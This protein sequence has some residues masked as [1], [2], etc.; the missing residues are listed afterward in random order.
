MEKTFLRGCRAEIWTR[1]CHTTGQR[2]IKRALLQHNWA[3]LHPSELRWPA[4]VLMRIH[5]LSGKR[6]SRHRDHVKRVRSKSDIL[7]LL[8]FRGR[9]CL[10][11][12]IEWVLL[13]RIPS[14]WS[15]WGCGRSH[16]GIGHLGCNGFHNFMIQ[17]S[18]IAKVR[19]FSV[20]FSA[21][22]FTLIKN[23]LKKF[24]LKQILTE[25][26]RKYIVSQHLVNFWPVSLQLSQ[27]IWNEQKCFA[28]FE[29]YTKK[30][31]RRI[32]NPTDKLHVKDHM[33]IKLASSKP[34]SKS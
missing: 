11:Y 12:S 20:P 17:T 9:P 33:S 5:W 30:A 23:P 1:A 26:W 27:Q 6:T 34:K 15:L 28:F 21:N 32:T 29:T 13:K 25:K 16:S 7:H 4:C 14:Y 3:T 24:T 31:K 22:R 10:R 19:N 18:F 8:C 2:P